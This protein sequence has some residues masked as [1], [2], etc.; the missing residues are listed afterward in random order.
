MRPGHKTRRARRATPPGPR[1]P[2]GDVYWILKLVIG[3]RSWDLVCVPHRDM[4]AGMVG[5]GIGNYVSEIAG[6]PVDCEALDAQVA[7]GKMLENENRAEI[8]G[9]ATFTVSQVFWVDEDAS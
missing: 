9:G 4:L 7:A 8:A 5:E 1:R 3:E 6:L 2:R